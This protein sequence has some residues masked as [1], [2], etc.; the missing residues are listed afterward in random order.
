MLSAEEKK[1]LGV[2][3]NEAML[4]GVE[5]DPARCLAAATL[6]VLTLPEAGAGS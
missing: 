2:A 5:L 1:S 4:L 6:A 3:L